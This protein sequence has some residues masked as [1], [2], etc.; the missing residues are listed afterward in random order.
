MNYAI[1][2]SG[3]K[4]YKT[5]VG[6]EILVDK[7]SNL[8]GDTITFPEVLLLRSNDTI[9]V[10][11]PFVSNAEVIGKVIEVIKGEKITISKFKAKVHYRRKMGFRPIYSKV[12]IESVSMRGKSAKRGVNKSSVKTKKAKTLVKIVKTIDPFD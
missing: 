1:I 10:G 5:S 8:K 11:N 9:V 12:K 4:Q 2:T 3:G 6:Q 7:L